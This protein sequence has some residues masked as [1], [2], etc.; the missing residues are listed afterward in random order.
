M[1]P[2]PILFVASEPA[3][4]MLLSEH[5]VEIHASNPALHPSANESALSLAPRGR[6]TP[7]AIIEL[8]V[9]VEEASPNGLVVSMGNV[10]ISKTIVVTSMESIPP[11]NVPPTIAHLSLTSVR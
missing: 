7:M 6:Q 2:T 10:A 3:V 5:L 9:L 8:P 11:P 4:S 1:V